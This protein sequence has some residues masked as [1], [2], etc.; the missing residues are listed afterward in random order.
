MARS[1]GKHRW[2]APVRRLAL[3]TQNALEL[4]KLG[5]FTDPQSAPYKVLRESA[6]ARLRRYGGDD[7]R[8]AVTAPVVLIPPLMLTAEIYDVAPE[9]SALRVVA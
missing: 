4:A 2:R 3:A 1:R 5:H 8:P 6:V 9:I 7:Y